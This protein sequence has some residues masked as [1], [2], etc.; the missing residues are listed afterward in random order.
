MT[1]PIKGFLSPGPN[2]P[3]M[4]EGQLCIVMRGTIEA[5]GRNQRGSAPSDPVPLRST[6]AALDAYPVDRSCWTCALHTPARGDGTD[7]DF[8][9]F[10]GRAIPAS[11]MEGGNASCLRFVDPASAFVDIGSEPERRCTT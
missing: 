8:C 10:Y 2:G 5:I 9:R 4:T 7:G 11:A 1:T 6:L 3:R